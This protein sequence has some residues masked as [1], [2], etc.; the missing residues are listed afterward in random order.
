MNADVFM[1]YFV[2]EMS[3]EL[4]CSGAQISTTTNNYHTTSRYAAKGTYLICHRL[5][6]RPDE[7][8]TTT[9]KTSKI[10]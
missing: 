1:C 7:H 3:N 2:H 5:L 9:F 10:Y 8:D 6:A 4:G